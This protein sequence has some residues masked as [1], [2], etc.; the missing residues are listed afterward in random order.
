MVT[1]DHVGDV[2]VGS[3]S[4]ARRS[5]DRSAGSAIRDARGDAAVRGLLH[6]HEGDLP[7]VSR[8][9]RDVRVA[10]EA[11]WQTPSAGWFRSGVDRG[12]RERSRLPEFG[13][14]LADHDGDASVA[15]DRRSRRLADCRKLVGSCSPDA[16]VRTIGRRRPIDDGLAD[17]RHRQRSLGT[18][19]RLVLARQRDGVVHPVIRNV[20]RTRAGRAVDGSSLE[21]AESR[22][23]RSGLEF[24][25]GRHRQSHTDVPLV[26]AN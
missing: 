25:A 18:R 10:S 15:D 20:D 12:V 11:V 1:V 22:L 16:Y 3:S 2:R 21:V 8:D 17:L 6:T 26:A 5:A 14:W 4:S 7:G 19:C 24:G 13:V 9:D 23:G